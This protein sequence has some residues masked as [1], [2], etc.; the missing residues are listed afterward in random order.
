MTV[1]IGTTRVKLGFFDEA[2]TQLALAKHPTPTQPDQ[3]G[4]V[5]DVPALRGL[6]TAF[7]SGLGEDLRARIERIAIAGVGE[8]GGL[9]AP[10]LSL[11]SPMI[12]WFDQRGAPLLAALSDEERD[13]IYRI[14]GLPASPNY[15][16]SKL[17]WAAQHT[18]SVG[19]NLLWLNISEYL[20]ATMT[21]MRW[22]E[23]TLASRTMALDL[24]S[25]GWSPRIA[26]LAGIDAALLP[27][28]RRAAEGQPVAADFAERV[29]LPSTVA[30]H[31]VGHDHMVGGV[32]AGL[33]PG[34][35]LNST[36]TTEGILMLRDQPSTDE[37]MA[38]AQLANGIAC[39]GERFTLFASIPTGGAAFAALQSML[40]TST[41]ALVECVESL[42]DEYRA[43][44][45]DLAAIPVVVPQ[46]RGSPPPRK[47]A[48]ARGAIANLGTDVRP[49]DIVFGTFLGMALQFRTV[50]QLFGP[51]AGPV[52]VI[53]PASENPLWLHLKA[54]VLQAELSVSTFPE[55]VSRG[56]Q[57][58]AS[59]VATDWTGVRPFTVSPDS[60]RHAQLLDWH[61]E[62]RTV[63]RDLSTVVW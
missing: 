52:K 39:D 38:A 9:V 58:L 33:R 11:A 3:W 27:P 49:A 30:V 54:D 62:S 46:F 22:A 41:A 40:G 57:A 6:V 23:Y 31:V 21:G 17:A 61:E 56:A 18:T 2:G 26:E 19:E 43:G 48:R 63:L 20:A 28:L 59:A 4:V 8:S 37:Q 10:D 35:I 45:I 15:G 5:Y 50:A 29:C 14:T 34:E 12:L 13:E 55:V 32:G 36:G 44:A 25:S 7:I 60:V 42:A 16:L 47:S 51:A 53:G 24:A 1:D